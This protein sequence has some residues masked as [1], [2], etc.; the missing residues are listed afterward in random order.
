LGSY[1][2][3][4]YMISSMCDLQL[5]CPVWV[6]DVCGESGSAAPGTG[7]SASAAPVTSRDS[8]GAPNLHGE[9][10][11]AIKLEGS[12]TYIYRWL[13]LAFVSRQSRLPTIVPIHKSL[14]Y[15]AQFAVSMAPSPR[16]RTCLPR[17]SGS[18]RTIR[19]EL[20]ARRFYSASECPRSQ[21]LQVSPSL[22]V[23]QLN[24]LRLD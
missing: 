1:L 9:H 15:S 19:Q 24:Q 3:L 17:S 18:I 11:Y 14:L 21:D 8:F 10:D 23:T 12:V 7:A 22:I 5:R 16:A 13:R 20:P 2:T 4:P 6:D